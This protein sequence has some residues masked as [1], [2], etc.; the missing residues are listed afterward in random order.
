MAIFK[1]RGQ[2]PDEKEKVVEFW[3]EERDGEIRL[4]ADG[5]YILNIEKNGK[6]HLVDCLEGSNIGLSLYCGQIMLD[7]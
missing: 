4:I 7:E 3:L 6:L 1:V 2:E 5:Y